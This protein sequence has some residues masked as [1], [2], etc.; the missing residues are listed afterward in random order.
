MKKVYLLVGQRGSGKSFYAKRLVEKYPELLLVSRDEILIEK[1]GSTD[2]SAYD[3]SQEYAGMILHERLKIELS[4][5]EN[6]RLILDTWTGYSRE[7]KYLLEDLRKYG[8][9]HIAALY[10]T[11]PLELVNSWFWQKPG[12]ARTSEMRMRKGQDLSYFSDDAPA[13][14]Y[15]TFHE[16]AQGIDSDGFDEVI[17]VEPQGELVSLS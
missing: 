1:F 14:D 3:G 6:A 17:R 15:K 13:R 4:V 2:T 16:L 10:L 5:R 8:A 7:R 12:I 9:N 11:T